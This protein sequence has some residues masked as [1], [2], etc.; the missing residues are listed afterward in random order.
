MRHRVT[1]DEGVVDIGL[2]YTFISRLVKPFENWA[3]FKTG[4]I[5]ADGE[6]LVPKR[7]RDAEQKKSFQMFDLLVLKLKKLLAKV[8]GGQTRLA[9]F[10]AAL[11]LVTESGAVGNEDALELMTE[12]QIDG[13][14]DEYCDWYD[15]GGKQLLTEMMETKRM[16]SS[17]FL[18]EITE[19]R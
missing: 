1:L 7:E 15:S 17:V 6:I 14:V 19:G 16:R 2:V 4:V 18:R 3:A 10:G 8:P 12:K 5:D 11:W 13:A 9:T